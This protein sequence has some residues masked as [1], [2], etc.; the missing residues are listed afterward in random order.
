MKPLKG[1]LHSTP[2]KASAL[3][4]AFIVAYW[5]PLKTMAGI[6]WTD[7]DYSYGFFIPIVSM[8]LFWDNRK[9]LQSVAFANAWTVLPFLALSVLVSLYGILGSSGNI[10]MPIVP[11]LVILFAA[12]CFGT[13]VTKR[14]FLPL[15]FLIFMIPVPDIVERH[16]GLFLKNVSTQAGA[17]MIGLFNI[18]V[19]VSGNVIDLGVSQLQVVDAC[20]GMRGVFALLALGVIY[21]YFFEK[22]PW[23]R[24]VCV[25]ATMPI[26]VATN[27][28]RIGITGILT[29]RYGDVM[30]EGFFHGFSGW[31]LFVVAF[32]LLFVTGR[33]LRFF[34]SKP[35][36]PS[37][38]A[39]DT[40]ADQKA[41]LRTGARSD[42]NRGF[43]ICLAILALV[44]LV[45]LSTKALPPIKIR[46]DLKSFPLAFSRWQGRFE[47]VDPEIIVQSGAEEAFSGIYG[48]DGYG[49]VSLYLGYRSTAFLSSGNFFHSPT[50][51]LPSSG[52]TDLGT[53][54][55]AI[56][57]VP[58]FKRL[59]VTEMVIANAGTRQLVY[60]WFQTKDQETPDKNVNRFHLAMHALK[61]DNTHD[62]FIRPI[63]AIGPDEKIEDAE[64][65]MDRFVRDMMAAL[66]TFLRERQ[67]EE[68]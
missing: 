18:P 31:I 2:A 56:E 25:L 36:S 16:L 22:V 23:K 28:L 19:H 15:A 13:S 63:T 32:A 37:R 43:V 44:G 11:I 61:R 59:V 10:A 5:V 7:D 29:E 34:P 17:S 68:K 41:S 54:T 40:R 14:F 30:A 26:A 50:V 42:I 24:V 66:F 57:N 39:R 46:G 20:N 33:V 6:W 55:H 1:L 47:P 60:F 21:A 48:S 64:K 27:A 45:T 53:S 49:A 51:C 62:L 12:F 9:A 35:S 4:V 58:L 3:L 67:F 8:Y 65:R 52:W 38:Q